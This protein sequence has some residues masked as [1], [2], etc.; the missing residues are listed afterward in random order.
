MRAPDSILARRYFRWNRWS[1]LKER[2]RLVKKHWD[3]PRAASICTH[4]AS[5]SE[6]CI[7]VVV[8][9][10]GVATSSCYPRP[11][12]QMPLSANHPATPR[13]AFIVIRDGLPLVGP[14]VGRHTT[15]RSH[16]QRPCRHPCFHSGSGILSLFHSPSLT[17]PA[18]AILVRRLSDEDLLPLET[19]ML[20]STSPLVDVPL[21]RSR[22][23]AAPS[24]SHFGGGILPL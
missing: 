20:M 8:E 21:H 9:R 11:S 19:I 22:R 6:I 7:T 1:D 13:F 10:T 24:I 14:T 18:Q 15:H 2:S 3:V 12:T 17:Q 23:A 16:L 4:L 5:G